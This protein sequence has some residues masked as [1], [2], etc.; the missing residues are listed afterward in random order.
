MSCPACNPCCDDQIVENI[1]GSQGDAG[2]NGAD[3]LDGENAYT[4]TTADFTM[5]AVSGTVT[6]QVLNSDWATQTQVIYVQTAGYMEVQ[7]F[8]DSTSVILENLGY[9]GNA[10]PATNIPS[11]SRVSPSGQR[12]PAGASGAPTDATYIT[13]T[14]NGSLSQETPLDGMGDGVLEWND[15]TDV[16]STRPI[17][18]A[19][20]EIPRIDDA[21]GLTNGEAVFATA[22]GI[23]SLADAAARTALGLGTAAVED[24]GVGDGDVALVDE[25]GGL[26]NGELLMATNNGIESV[27]GTTALAAIGLSGVTNDVLIYQHLEAT[28]V[29][30][31]TFNNGGW[32][33]VDL[34]TEV[35][36]TGNHGSLL[37]GV[38]TLDA[39]IYRARWRVCGYRVENFIS[40]LL[41]NTGMNVIG[42]GS[43]SFSAAVDGDP[44]YSEGESRFEILV[45]SAIILQ[46]RCQTSNPDDGYG[47]ACNF[48]D[49]DGNGNG[50]MYA[51]LVLEREVG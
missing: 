45:Q 38:V 9:D 51:E 47:L 22:N 50:N 24:S 20:T 27:D 1:P 29:D 3:G 25:V 4:L 31:G 34:N 13:R 19:D 36:D 23:E 43:T 30:G 18:V 48:G 46:A 8:P 32:N 2:A 35:V 14:A 7:S 49:I 28:A 33:T 42:L 15:T 41:D 40:R 11:S 5:P 37:A 39:G 6:V 16:L 44:H 26:D 17:G 21:A 10:A 12:G